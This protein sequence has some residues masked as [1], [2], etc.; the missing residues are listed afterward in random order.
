VLAG[1]CSRSAVPLALPCA[2]AYSRTLS[3]LSTLSVSTA[4]YLYTFADDSAR[5]NWLKIARGAGAI[6]TFGVGPAWVI[7]GLQDAPA[8]KAITA[9]GGTV[10]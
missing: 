8:R 1:I 9:A 7:Q 2:Y 5:D 6:G 10:S 4:V 3:Q